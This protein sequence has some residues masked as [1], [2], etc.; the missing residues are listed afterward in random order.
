MYGRRLGWD[1]WIE[2]FWNDEFRAAAVDASSHDLGPLPEQ[3]HAEIIKEIEACMPA[4]RYGGE[5]CDATMEHGGRRL[6]CTLSAGHLLHRAEGVRW[7]EPEV[8]EDLSK[9]A[10]IE[11]LVRLGWTEKDRQEAAILCEQLAT[12]PHGKWCCD[13]KRLLERGLALDAPA[14]E[15]VAAAEKESE[16]ALRGPKVQMELQWADALLLLG[17]LGTTDPR[18]IR[19]LHATLREACMKARKR[20]EKVDHE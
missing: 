5:P 19:R 2:E 6:R 18:T 12:V 4:P 8:D 16:S 11:R 14:P 9:S 10:P 3:L 15:P 7:S 17:M 13:A 20:V 1:G